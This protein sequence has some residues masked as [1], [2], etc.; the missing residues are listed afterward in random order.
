MLDVRCW[1][2]LWVHGQRGPRR[3]PRVGGI[4]MRAAK[5]RKKSLWDINSVALAGLLAMAHSYPRLT[6]WATLFRHS[7]ADGFPRITSIPFVLIRGI[8]VCLLFSPLF[9]RFGK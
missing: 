4:E 2:F 9:P 3:Q 1:M 8:R 7:V 5:R 6:L